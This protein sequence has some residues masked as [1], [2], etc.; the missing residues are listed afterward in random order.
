MTDNKKKEEWK[1][2]LRLLL[3]GFAFYIGND[4]GR[5]NDNHE[6]EIKKFEDFI[7]EVRAEAL[8]EERKHWHL[9]PSG[10]YSCPNHEEHERLGGHPD[11]DCPI[12]WEQVK[13]EAL[14][15]YKSKLKKAWD[16]RVEEVKQGLDEEYGKNHSYSPNYEGIFDAL[17]KD[18]EV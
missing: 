11:I 13:S 14:S 12:K 15:A 16:E 9:A 1:Q 10:G 4:T 3:A 8:K 2:E 6:A 5:E 7:L 18:L 17:L